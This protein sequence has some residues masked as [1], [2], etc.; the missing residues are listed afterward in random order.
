MSDT[1]EPAQPAVLT[2]RR[3]RVLVITLNRPEAMNAINGDLS[4]GLW[5]AIQDL[6][7]DPGLTAG[8]LTGNG[9]G[10]C[11]G[12]DLKAFSRGEDIGPMVKFIRAGSEKPLICA[13]EGF[14]LAGGLELALS[15]DL[16]VAARGA[17]LGIPEVGVGLLAAGAGLFR[18]PGRV[19]YGKAMEMAITADPITAEE[20]AEHGLV[21]RLS[22]PGEALDTA[23][24]LAERIAR[25]APLAVA[26][27]KQLIRATQGST[28]DELWAL[29]RP[30]QKKVFASADAKEGPR[31]FAEKRRPE[32][33]GT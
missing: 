21:A 15:C 28:E 13:I 6:N 25:N 24:A 4:N 29:Q 27:S 2:E 30:L 7:N 33:S 10:F 26:A 19:G 16:L 12:M 8:V 23:L 32:W 17:K 11:A 20:A 1:N 18:L 31:A 5:S 22:E 9:R 3:D 14:A